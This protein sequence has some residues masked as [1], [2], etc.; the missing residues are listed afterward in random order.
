MAAAEPVSP[1][2]NPV[3]PVAPV[4][5]GTKTL[6]LQMEDAFTGIAKNSEPWVVNVKVLKV[7]DTPAAAGASDPAARPSAA[8]GSG[9]IVRSDGY[10]LTNDHVVDGATEVTVCLSDGR[11]FPGTVAADYRS[12]L[13]VIKINAGGSLPVAPF[14]DSSRVLPGQWAI[15]IGS[16]FDLQNTMTVGVISAVNRKQEIAEGQSDR[17]YPDLIQTD[18]AINPGNSGGPLLNIDG[19]VIGINVAIESPVEGS[20]GVGF[21][22][23]SRLAQS[24]MND[25]IT[26]GSVVRGYLGIQP[27]DLTPA[28]QTEFGVTSGAWVEE[29]EEDS[30]AG[31]SGIHAADIITSF[32]SQS[33]TGELSLREAISGTTPGKAVPVEL[34][35]NQSKVLVTVTIGPP[36]KSGSDIAPTSV[37]AVPRKLGLSVRTLTASDRQQGSLGTSLQGALVLGVV[38]NS[39][40]DLSGLQQG[41]IITQVGRQVITTADDCTKALT[42]INTGQ[43]ATVVVSRSTNGKIQEIALDLRP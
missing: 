38:P 21:A 30:P 16:P 8:T 23:P 19:Q 10:V 22:I 35:R 29:V 7:D 4:A 42:V 9:L 37:K 18:A 32:D 36:P 1:S 27:A 28:L 33:V 2:T 24:I 14:G 40:A 43:P 39:P 15:A 41:D 31:K 13:A 11:E 26:K 3:A 20:S 25:L 34:L 12:D 5:Q 17:Y 6:L